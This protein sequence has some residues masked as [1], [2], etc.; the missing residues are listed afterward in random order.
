[1]E[2]GC[3]QLLKDLMDNLPVGGTEVSIKGLATGEK[4]LVRNDVREGTHDI[5]V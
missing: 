2:Q 3:S 1:M 4:Q 5:R